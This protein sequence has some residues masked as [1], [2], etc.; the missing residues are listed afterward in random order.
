M[1]RFL[2]IVQ[3][4]FIHIWRD[5]RTLALIILLPAILLL[6][7][8]YGVSGESVDKPLVVADF[9]RTDASRRFIE[10]FT[11]SGKFIVKYTAQSE[12]EILNLIDRE[13]A[14]AG[15]WIPEDFGRSLDTNR[16][17]RVQFYVNGSDPAEAQTTNLELETISQ[18]A[19]QNIFSAQLA[20]RG[21]TMTLPISTHTLTLYNPDNSSKRYMVP[22]LIPMILQVQALLLTA[23]AIV[24]EREQG[25]MEQ[26]IV[27][28]IHSWELML[29]KIVP[30][31]LVG[32]INTV[33]TIAIAMVIFEIT[34]AGSLWLLI[35]LSMVF[36]LGSL[37]MGVLISN[38]SQTQMQAM[39]LAVGVVL[40]PAVILSGLLF[41][42][43]SM[44]LFTYLFSEILPITHYLTITRGIMMKG[45]GADF[46]LPSIWRLVAL[47]VFYFSASVLTFRKQ[48]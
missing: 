34:V 40:L 29:G 47:C 2:T 12:D 23:L 17:T 9:S 3:K 38:I 20:S 46:L 21:T 41:P 19:V 42:R 27:T 25:T 16:P 35:G 24:R 28:P 43:D 15:I 4:E 48:I 45:V 14:K 13:K 44:P 26:L 11:S 6:L 30:Y 5:P 36:I 32:F 31:L 18:V 33:A 7:L 22:G 1:E 39:Y 37:G 10:Y 8:G